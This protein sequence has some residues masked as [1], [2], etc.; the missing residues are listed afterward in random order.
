MVGNI[1]SQSLAQTKKLN[2]R[3]EVIFQAILLVHVYNEY[4]TLRSILSLFR[5]FFQLFF[6]F[7]F[8]IFIPL[9]NLYYTMYRMYC[10][11]IICR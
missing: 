9:F 4:V 6:E 2:W 7:L 10:L 11:Y 5:C 1:Y 8:C 3:L